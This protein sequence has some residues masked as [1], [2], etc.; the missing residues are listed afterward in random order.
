MLHELGYKLLALHCNFHLRGEESMRDQRFAEKLCREKQVELLVRDFDTEAVARERGISIEMAARDLRYEWF[1]GVMQERQA[2]AIAVAHHQDDQ[3]ETI[4]LNLVRGTGLRGLS[5]MHPRRDGIVRPLLCLSRQQIL[6]YLGSL[7]QPYVNDSTNGER[8][9]RRNIIRLDVLPL[10]RQL[11]PQASEALAHAASLVRRSMPYYEAGIESARQR[12]AVTDTVCPLPVDRTLLYEWLQGKGFNAAQLREM[13]AESPV[14]RQWLS[15]SHAVLRDRNG[16]LLR[17]LAD[18]DSKPVLRQELVDRIGETGPDVA[19]FDADLIAGEI[20]VRKVAGGD[21][22]VPFGMRGRKLLSD[23]LTDRKLS[24][25]EK[26]RQWVVTSG[27]D[28]I[29]VI[30]LRSDNRYRVTDATRRILCISRVK[31]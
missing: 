19:Y 9:A 18:G 23:F 14:G 25:F 13:T 26:E 3:A 8:I 22:F 15:S 24:R 21:W 16:L 2:Q 11:N 12:Q 1:R 29:W 27:S 30:G 7:G 28:I 20:Q 4:L 5:G 31:N 10:L 17:S 6:D